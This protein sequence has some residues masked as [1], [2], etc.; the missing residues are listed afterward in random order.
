MSALY[1]G[2][3]LAINLTFLNT[4]DFML[5]KGLM[6]AMSEGNL[7]PVFLVFIIIKEFI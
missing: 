7:L 5:E 2:N 1:L 4:G 6:S 3:Y